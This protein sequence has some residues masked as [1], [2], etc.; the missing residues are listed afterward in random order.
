MVTT[1]DKV[2][3]SVR[4]IV[5]VALV[6]MLFLF[7]AQ[8]ESKTSNLPALGAMTA[9]IA[10]LTL[11]FFDRATV[12]RFPAFAGVG[13]FLCGSA[14]LVIQLTAFRIAGMAAMWIGLIIVVVGAA[15]GTKDARGRTARN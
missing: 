15:L 6:V 9:G 10:L 8:S 3:R 1:S 14:L 4:T 5:A 11:W 12:G 2:S 13:I 7:L